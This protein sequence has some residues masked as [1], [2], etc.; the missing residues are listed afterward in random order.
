MSEISSEMLKAF[1]IRIEK[2]EENKSYVLEDIKDI[3]TEAKG[4][5]FDVKIIKQIVKL[6]KMEAE[7][8]REAEDLLELY[9]SAIGM[10]I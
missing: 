4:K 3:Y 10:E 6:R 1:I 7:K 2:M 5:G 8:R 9:M